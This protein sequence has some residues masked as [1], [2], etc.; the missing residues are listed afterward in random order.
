MTI[1]LFRVTF[2]QHSEGAAPGL[3]GAFEYDA[4]TSNVPEP[5]VFLLL[6]TGLAIGGWRQRR[7]I[8]RR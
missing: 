1:D 5:A 2:E 8:R 7:M 6:A 4:S 3:F